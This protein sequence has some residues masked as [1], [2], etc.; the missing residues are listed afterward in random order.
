MNLSMAASQ[1]FIT[2]GVD[3]HRDT[4]HAAVLDEVGGLLGDAE[5]PSTP[6]GY[7]ALLAWMRGHGTL[8]VVGVEGTGSYGAGLARYLHRC[9]VAVVEVDRP[10]RAG[11]RQHVRRYG[12]E[13]RPRFTVPRF[14]GKAGTVG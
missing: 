1:R 10:D 6:D 9:Q 8:R 2:G 13:I 14:T 4:H 3:T 11:R 7:R 12:E 5:F